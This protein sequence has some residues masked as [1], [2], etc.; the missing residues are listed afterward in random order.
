VTDLVLAAGSAVTEFDLQEPGWTAPRAHADEA[1]IRMAG[2]RLG[3]LPMRL[4]GSPWEA[5][6]F[7]EHAVDRFGDAALAVRVRELLP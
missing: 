1:T 7:R 5:A 6:R 4:G 2:R 3:T